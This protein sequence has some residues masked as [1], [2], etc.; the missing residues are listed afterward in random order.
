QVRAALDW[1]HSNIAAITETQARLTELPAPPF[2]ESERAQAVKLLL[3]STGL[4]VQIDK[5]GNVIA[6]L[7]GTSAKS[8]HTEAVVISAHLDTVF[9]AAPDTKVRREGSRLVAPGI[10]DN[11]TGLAALIAIAQAIT[12]AHLKPATSVLFVAD[13]G[14]EG[15]GNLRGMRAL[16]D[17]YGSR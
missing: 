17:A 11:G 10:S 1:L 13:V 2:Q 12:A 14:E 5:I 9:P 3:E 6:T 16:I 15:E 7:P 4:S 8:E